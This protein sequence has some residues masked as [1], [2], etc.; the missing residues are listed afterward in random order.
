LHMLWKNLLNTMLG[1][2][3]DR[4]VSEPDLAEIWARS[5]KRVPCTVPAGVVHWASAACAHAAPGGT[6]IAIANSVSV[7]HGVRARLDRR[8]MVSVARAIVVLAGRAG[9]M[10]SD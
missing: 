3:G 4:P 9:R 5:L 2:R 6:A 7:S 8:P 1:A 10:L